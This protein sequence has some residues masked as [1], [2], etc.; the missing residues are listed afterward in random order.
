MKETKNI[1][2]RLTADEY[3]AFDTICREKGYS[4]TGKIR[5]FIRKLIKEELGTARVSANE[6][7]KIKQGI[8]EI[9]K[10]NYISFDELKSNVRKTSVADNQNRK[11]CPKKH[12]PTQPGK[13]KKNYRNS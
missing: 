2:L 1:S 8:Q 4:K 12:N 10:G 5:E 6:W 3:H 9:E 13:S 7:K 11:Y